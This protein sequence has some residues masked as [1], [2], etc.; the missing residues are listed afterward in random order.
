M[1]KIS[2]KT[3]DFNNKVKTNF[4]GGD[5]TSDSG[6]LL[7]KE[8]DKK[9]G[10][11]QTIKDCLDFDDDVNHRKHENADV[12]VQRILQNAAG[13][14][15]DSA[16]NDLREDT[17]FKTILEKEQLASQP[18]LSRL[19]EISSEKT[20]KQLQ[21][22]NNKLL[23]N[24]YKNEPP[25]EII[26]DLDSTISKTYGNQYGSAYNEHYSHEGYHPLMLFDGN[27]GDALKGELRAG[28]VY[29]SR[30]VVR[31]IG[32]VLK[33]YGK[34]F[35]E[36]LFYLRA[37]SGF[38]KPG[39][40]RMCEEHN[41]SYA[42]RLKAN[43][44]LYE[45]AEPFEE[46]LYE[47]DSIQLEDSGVIYGEF[48]YQA[49][50]WEHSRRVV[51]KIEKPKCEFALRYTFIVTNIQDKEPED[52][53]DFYFGR[54]TMENFIKE[55]KNGF[56]VDR[57]SSTDFWSNASKLQQMLLAYNLN[58]WLRRLAFPESYKSDRIFTIRMRLIKIAARVVKTGR[59][60]YFK[61]ASS[62]PY[63]KFFFSVLENIQ[64]LEFA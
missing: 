22:A 25:E 35:Q 6:M 19:N 45:L 42:I 26:F 30:Q 37:D 11:S 58:N 61:L 48:S 46:K 9:M 20:M 3:M 15:A 49:K 1:T 47:K 33:N 24:I 41:T 10:F 13:Y 2:E 56:A 57:M 21:D 40:Y 31:F 62:C 36:I 39:L 8:L 51:V 63:K 50:S 54:S 5:L 64:K 18:T 60:L 12:V 32:P 28:N 23:K 59:Y 38:A 29:T 14:H 52:L 44:K 27:T 53:I 7:Y 17:L 43:A 4:D 55:A 34:A 16:A